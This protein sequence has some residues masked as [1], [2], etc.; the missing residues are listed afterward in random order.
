M[1]VPIPTDVSVIHIPK[2][3]L[4]YSTRSTWLLSI[5][6]IFVRRTY[7]S[8]RTSTNLMPIASLKTPKQSASL[9]SK[10]YYYWFYLF[11]NHQPH[12]PFLQLDDRPIRRQQQLQWIWFESNRNNNESIR[13]VVIFRRTD[14]WLIHS[15]PIVVSNLI[16]DYNNIICVGGTVLLFGFVVPFRWIDRYERKNCERER[17]GSF[18]V[19]GTV[20]FS[21]PWRNCE[22]V[23]DPFDWD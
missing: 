18:C 4:Y 11:K 17:D 15:K 13:F 20:L 7:G 2:P 5:H 21:F 3:L 8:L 22:A 14:D 10:K 6:R 1:V 16:E 9:S 12:N 19:C 23:L